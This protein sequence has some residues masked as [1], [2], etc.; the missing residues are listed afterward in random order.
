MFLKR[1]LI[2]FISL[3][4]NRYFDCYTGGKN[5]PVFFDITQTAPDLQIL[6]RHIETIRK[7]LE[8]VQAVNDGVK[9]YHEVD[10]LQYKISAITDPD[11]N[12]NV[13]ML[14][15]MGDFSGQA[16][17]AMPQTCQ[18]LKQIPGVYQSFFSILDPGKNIPEH[19]GMYRG[20]LRYHL[21]LRIPAVDPPVFLIKDQRYT[22]AKDASVL[23]DDSWNHQVVNHCLEA[24]VVLVVD[25]YRPMPALPDRV[26]RFL[27][28]NLIKRFYAEKVLKSLA[29]G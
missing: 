29:E 27:T 12:W 17:R 13:F 4:A 23:F 14:Y 21:G 24:R 28:K 22:W 18:L 20:Y 5:R 16:L 10:M 8:Q 26:N 2:Q 19:K 3:M 25:I 9:Q 6:D 7:E 15:M 1:K 11:K